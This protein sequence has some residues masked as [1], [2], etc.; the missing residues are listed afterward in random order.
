MASAWCTCSGPAAPRTARR[1]EGAAGGVH[2][3]PGSGDGC[4]ARSATRG[5]THVEFALDKALRRCPTHGAALWPVAQVRPV[6]FKA[7]R[8][9]CGSLLIQAGASPAAVSAVLGHADVRTTMERYAALAPDFLRSEVERLR[10]GLPPP[11]EVPKV[12][13]AGAPESI[14]ATVVPQAPAD[15]N[16]AGASAEIPSEDPAPT[17]SGKRDSNPRPSA[18]ERASLLVHTIA[19]IRK[20]LQR[21]E[22][23]MTAVSSRPSRSRAFS[24]FLLPPCYPEM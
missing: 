3:R 23:G 5:C 16:G 18:W 1:Q 19:T 12:A 6:Q 10:L 9:T 15:V 22:A 17:W 11:A 7:T 4:G 20:G 24:D 2:H 8:S 14:G 13:A 21:L